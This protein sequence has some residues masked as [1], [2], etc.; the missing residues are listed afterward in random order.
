MK[1]LPSVFAAVATLALASAP[2]PHAQTMPVVPQNS[3][4][5][6]MITSVTMT[7]CVERNTIAQPA[8]VSATADTP[9][10]HF[11]LSSARANADEEST[12]DVRMLAATMR[13]YQLYGTDAALAPELGHMVEI[14]GTV[15]KR[16]AS[17]KLTVISLK[18]IASSCVR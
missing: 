13:T 4:A 11:M 16:D 18:T 2:F 12:P 3:A 5:P 14:A 15:N 7:G 6:D 17:P 1:T 9:V 10:S 8:A